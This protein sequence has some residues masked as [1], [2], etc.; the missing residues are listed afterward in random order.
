MKRIISLILLLML[1]L[2][3]LTGCMLGVYGTDEEIK[4]DN[5]EAEASDSMTD[6]VVLEPVKSVT[7][8]D[9][10]A[11]SNAG[12][13]VTLSEY[14]QFVTPVNDY[15]EAKAWNLKYK[16]VQPKTDPYS[17]GVSD[18]TDG[19]GLAMLWY[20]G[21]YEENYYVILTCRPSELKNPESYEEMYNNSEYI[22]QMIETGWANYEPPKFSL[23]DELVLNSRVSIVFETATYNG[24]I[25]YVL[26]DED[27]MLEYS[28]PYGTI[29]AEKK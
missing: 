28:V 24:K 19:N 29:I 17:S 23:E 10:L 12:E 14:M 3:T 18:I 22:L 26:Y 8:D 9:L 6:E 27:T 13:Y 11:R 2:P 16:R 20:L 1:T 7:L 4:N 21:Q 15:V 25:N 5:L